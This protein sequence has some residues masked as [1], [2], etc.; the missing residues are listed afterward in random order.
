VTATVTTTIILVY[1]YAVTCMVALGVLAGLVVV[2]LQGVQG[3]FLDKEIW[4]GV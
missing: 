4:L 3:G 2:V 1:L